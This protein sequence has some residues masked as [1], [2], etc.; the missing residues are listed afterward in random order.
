MLLYTLN[1]FL[2]QCLRWRIGC[3]GSV[4]RLDEIF[5]RPEDMTE[6]PERTPAG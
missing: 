5:A 1:L 4:K 6:L 3:A 2:P